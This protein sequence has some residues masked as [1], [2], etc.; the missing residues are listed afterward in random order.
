M[1]FPRKKVSLQTDFLF[2]NSL[3]DSSMKKSILAKISAGYRANLIN[4][5][6]EKSPRWPTYLLYFRFAILPTGVV[7]QPV[8]MSLSNGLV[9]NRHPYVNIFGNPHSLVLF[10]NGKRYY[11][12]NRNHSRL[13]SSILMW[14]GWRVI[15]M[16]VLHLHF[17]VDFCG[18]NHIALNGN[19]LKTTVI[20]RDYDVIMQSPSAWVWNMSV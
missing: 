6:R 3:H 12:H 8:M 9:K 20:I 17:E 14:A 1:I 2:N 5:L 19:I 4:I 10:N 7:G 16:N 18:K 13:W 11:N 15:I